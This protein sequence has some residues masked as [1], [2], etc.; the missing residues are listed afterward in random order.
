MWR[1]TKEKQKNSDS[2]NVDSKPVAVTVALG[3]QT[4]SGYQSTEPDIRVN[5]TIVARHT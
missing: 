4:L 2:I 5:L 3:V 1:Q